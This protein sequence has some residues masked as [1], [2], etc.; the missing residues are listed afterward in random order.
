MSRFWPWGEKCQRIT[1]LYR[2]WL[3]VGEFANVLRLQK[4]WFISILGFWSLSLIRVVVKCEFYCL[5]DFYKYKNCLKFW[6]YKI[7]SIWLIAIKI[8]KWWLLISLIWN[9]LIHPSSCCKWKMTMINWISI[10]IIIYYYFKPRSLVI[11]IVFA[12]TKLVAIII[13]TIANN[14]KKMCISHCAY[15]MQQIFTILPL[16]LNCEI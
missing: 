16:T 12:I 10:F 11:A 14:K 6:H 9:V 1:F 4:Q 15:R 13:T 3:I 5:V 2:R 7:N 8:S